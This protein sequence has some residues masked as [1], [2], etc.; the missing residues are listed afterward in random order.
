MR[1]NQR[2]TRYATILQHIK[3]IEPIVTKQKLRQRD[4]EDQI[5][6]RPYSLPF[7]IKGILQYFSEM[8]H[9]FLLQISRDKFLIIL[10]PFIPFALK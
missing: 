8:L 10:E 5:E 7:N 2:V 4:W 3:E 1:G 6:R 9:Y